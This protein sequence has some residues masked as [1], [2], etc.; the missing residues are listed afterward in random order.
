ME[1]GHSSEVPV[2]RESPAGLSLANKTPKDYKV[3][4]VQQ[5]ERISSRAM[6][7]ENRL[8]S[9]VDVHRFSAKEPRS[10]PAR[11]TIIQCADSGD[12]SW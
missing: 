10:S 9:I 1:G 3:T 7:Y 8:T 5:P 4:V 2:A 6:S 11:N 12:R